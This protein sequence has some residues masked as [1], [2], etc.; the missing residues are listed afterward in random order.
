MPS[1][2]STWTSFDRKQHGQAFGVIDAMRELRKLNQ[3]PGALCSICG[4]KTHA[5]LMVLQSEIEAMPTALLTL[6]T[7]AQFTGNLMANICG[8]SIMMTQVDHEGGRWRS[9]A[10]TGYEGQLLS[11][12]AILERIREMRAHSVLDI[13]QN[14][15][16]MLDWGVIVVQLAPILSRLG[17][18]VAVRVGLSTAQKEM[19]AGRMRGE[20]VR[21]GGEGKEKPSQTESIQRGGNGQGVRPADGPGVELTIDYDEWLLRPISGCTLTFEEALGYARSSEESDGI[22]AL[23]VGPTDKE[24]HVTPDGA[25]TILSCCQGED[26]KEMGVA[27][28]KNEYGSASKSAEGRG[29]SIAFIQRVIELLKKRREPDSAQS[30]LEGRLAIIATYYE[31]PGHTVPSEDWLDDGDIEDIHQALGTPA[32]IWD[33]DQSRRR[34]RLIRPQML[35]SAAEAADF[36]AT[37]KTWIEASPSHYTCFGLS[38]GGLVALPDHTSTGGTIHEETLRQAASLLVRASQQREQIRTRIE[39]QRSNPREARLAAR[40]A[41]AAVAAVAAAK[42]GVVKNVQR[43]PAARKTVA[44]KLA[45]RSRRE[46]EPNRAAPTDGLTTQGGDAMETSSQEGPPGRT[47]V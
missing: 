43:K 22:F 17:T 33:T 34:G 19:F 5:A 18:E 15:C 39:A 44:R 2:T 30:P 25:C 10:I 12:Q 47:G 3:D 11:A 23:T 8:G 21:R 40:K 9:L 32:A 4:D 14:H 6:P 35:M 29:Q 26:A 16:E 36:M 27:R 38:V 37:A 31:P 20:Q 42:K 45:V 7:A 1:A 13:S 28:P 46:G 24:R 41:S